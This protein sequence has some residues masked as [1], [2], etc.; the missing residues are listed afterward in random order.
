MTRKQ[1]ALEAEL[2][3]HN[4][5]RLS[6]ATMENPRLVSILSSFLYISIDFIKQR[7]LLLDVYREKRW[8]GQSAAETFSFGI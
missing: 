3:E 7:Q 2:K 4:Y 8:R 1:F 5:R 6:T